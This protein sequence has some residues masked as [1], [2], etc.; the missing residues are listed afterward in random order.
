[1]NDQEMTDFGWLMID[2][3]KKC[4]TRPEK[5]IDQ[6]LSCTN[7]TCRCKTRKKE[8]EGLK[9]KEID[10]NDYEVVPGSQCEISVTPRG[11]IHIRETVRKKKG[12][13]H[14]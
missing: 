2:A 1:M 13:K 6:A 14:E 10:L 4:W 12:L 11:N 9:R 8:N 5:R 3:M 7:E